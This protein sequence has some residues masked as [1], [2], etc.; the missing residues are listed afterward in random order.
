MSRERSSRRDNVSARSAPRT[1]RATGGTLRSGD[2][3]S[4]KRCSSRRVIAW[5]LAAEGLAWRLSATMLKR[6]RYATSSP[7]ASY[8]AND[9]AYPVH[10]RRYDTSQ[11]VP[12]SVR[13]CAE[14]SQSRREARFK[15][16]SAI[17][18]ESRRTASNGRKAF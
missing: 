5:L 10:N 3:A 2:P 12:K 17:F 1:R 16:I 9:D 14:W 11:V 13:W 6:A 7:N 15:L 18:C 4:S 8:F